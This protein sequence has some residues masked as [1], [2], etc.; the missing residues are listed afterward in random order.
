MQDAALDAA[1]TVRRLA[2]GHTA[3]NTARQQ[4]AAAAPKKATPSARRHA[5]PTRRHLRVFI[6]RR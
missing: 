1:S 4:G 2:L 3:K 6:L 5:V